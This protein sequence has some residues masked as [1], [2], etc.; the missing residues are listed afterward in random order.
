M[1][2]FFRILEV[3]GNSSG[4]E[5]T[6]NSKKKRKQGK[7]GQGSA[8]PN[9]KVMCL[10]SWERTR[11]RDPPLFLG[12]LVWSK[13]ESQAAPF[14]G[15]HTIGECQKG[16]PRRGRDKKRR[17]NLRHVTTIS[18]QFGRTA[19]G[20]QAIFNRIIHHRVQILVRQGIPFSFA[21]RTASSELWSQETQPPLTPRQGPEYRGRV[22]DANP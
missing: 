2:Q 9:K 22:P 11:T 5:K 7:E 16:T 17:D 15:V 10:I 4:G 14:F 1:R 8:P 19:P 6:R 13:R 3:L 12:G 20:A 21:K 18:E